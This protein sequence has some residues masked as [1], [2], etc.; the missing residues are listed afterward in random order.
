M[1]EEVTIEAGGLKI[2]VEYRNF[3][4]DRGPAMR[5]FGETERGPV[6]VLRFDC[7]DTDPH[8]HYDPD[9]MNGF[10]HLDRTVVPDV[11]AWS[12]AQLRLNIQEMVKT[13]GYADLAERLDEKAIAECADQVHA[14]ILELTP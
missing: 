6:Q 2:R 10:H 1:S 3:G 14:A 13:A 11:V 12:V 4:G 9:G 8:Y 5:V 7:F